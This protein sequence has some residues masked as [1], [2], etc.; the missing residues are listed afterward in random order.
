M[1]YCSG[2]GATPT[3]KITTF[4]TLVRAE[5]DKCFAATLLKRNSDRALADEAT[6]VAAQAVSAAKATADVSKAKK[7]IDDAL[8]RVLVI[9]PQVKSNVAN[10]TAIRQAAT[11][12][13]KGIDERAAAARRV[14]APV[15][16]ATVFDPSLETSSSLPKAA[17]VGAAVVAALLLW[18][19]KR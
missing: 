5:A 9:L 14:A 3:D 6:T 4:A 2:L 18:P 15:P 12:A 10:L 7:A 19:R 13:K 17:I 8:A 16:G 1:A 11:D